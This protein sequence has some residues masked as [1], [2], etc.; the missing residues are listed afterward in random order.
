MQYSYSPKIPPI[1]Y[2]HVTSAGHIGF[3]L[4]LYKPIEIK[5][6][7]HHRLDMWIRDVCDKFSFN[8]KDYDF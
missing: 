1:V 7:G 5:G 8:F 2:E 6:S 3:F 4:S